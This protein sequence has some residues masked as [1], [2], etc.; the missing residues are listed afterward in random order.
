MRRLRNRL[1]DPIGN[2][3][4]GGGGD[5]ANWLMSLEGAVGRSGGWGLY[6]GRCG[7]WGALWVAEG[8]AGGWVAQW[9][10]ENNCRRWGH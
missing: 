6:M 10:A 3:V 9:E 1:G 2:E 8:S 4:S 7:G 5:W